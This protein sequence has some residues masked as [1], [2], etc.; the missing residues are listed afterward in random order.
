MVGGVTVNLLLGM[1]IYIG[2]LFTWGRDYLPLSE[3]KYGVHVSDLM[4]RQ[5]LEEG[6]RIVGVAGAHPKTLEDVTRAILIDGARE[7]TV[8]RGGVQQRITL[9]PAV[10]DS[11]LASGEK[12]LFAP[13]VPFIVDTVMAD[14]PALAAGMQ[15]G[16]IL[17]AVDN[18]VTKYYTDLREAMAD[19]KGKEVTVKVQRSNALLELRMTVTEEGTVG[20]GNRAPSAYFTMAHEEFNAISA[21]PAGIAYGWETLAAMCVRSSSCSRAAAPARSGASGPSGACSA[22]RGTGRCSG[23]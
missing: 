20:I 3:V 13:R 4:Q 5:G 22:P 15:K 10:H 12:S 23:T 21:I 19:R 9:S 18:V 16:D 6:D 8:E 7:L 17:V 2:I 14:G 1:A 11:I